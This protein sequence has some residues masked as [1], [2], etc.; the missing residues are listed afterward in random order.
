MDTLSELSLE[1]TRW[2]QTN[3]PNLEPFFS[4]ISALGGFEFYLLILTITYWCLEKKLGRALAYVLIFSY[5]INSMIKHFLRD[6]RPYWLNPDIGLVSEENYGMPSGH[7]QLVTVFLSM[8]AIYFRRLWL[9]IVT[10]ILILLMALS[11]V[12]LGVHDLDDVIGGIILGALILV[13]YVMWNRFLARRFAN[14]ILG[15][16]L[17][18]AILVPLVLVVVYATVLFIIGTPDPP[19]AIADYAARAERKSFDEMVQS[20]GFL[21]GSGAGFVLEVSRVRFKVTGSFWRRI[22]RYFVGI[23]VAAV[24]WLGMGELFPKDPIGLALPLFFLRSVIVSSWI[25]YFAPWTFVRLKLAD[26]HPEPEVTLSL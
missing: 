19:S 25:A 15:Q 18:L 23:I 21:L 3:Y 26:A 9:W 6:P 14:R 12:Y 22:A 7:A 5:V 13:G 2:L 1:F 11:R 17:L 16:R 10:L 8:I 4:G 24:I 20:V